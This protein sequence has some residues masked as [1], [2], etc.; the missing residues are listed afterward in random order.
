MT[1]LEVANRLVEMCLEGKV[2]EAQKEL[3][4]EN[5]V[6]IEPAGA[7]MQRAEGLANVIA[8]GE[9]FAAMIEERHGGSVSDPLV[10]GNYFSIAWSMEVTMKGM[11][12]MTMEEICVYKVENGK[13]TS[14]EFFYSQG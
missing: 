8:K 4:A 7:P 2:L 11:G 9:H 13:I 5:V 14:E 10:A 12:R 3:Y 6:S 1:T